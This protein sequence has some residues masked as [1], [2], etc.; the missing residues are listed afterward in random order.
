MKLFLP[1]ARATNFLLIVGFVSLGYALYIR[2]LGIEQ[3]QVGLSCAAGLDTWLC[4]SRRTVAILFQYSAFGTAA[5]IAI[6]VGVQVVS[7]GVLGAGLPLRSEATLAA[8]AE[9]IFGPAGWRM[10]IVCTA[11]ATFGTLAGDMLA[12]PRGFLPVSAA[13]LLPAAVAS[14]HPRYR[15]PH[16]AIGLYAGVA[17]VMALSGA[18][19]P[20]A[21]LSSGSILLV[22]FVVCVAAMRLRMRRPPPAGG[23][24]IPGGWTVPLAGV[25]IVV[26]LL[27]HLSATEAAALGGTVLVATL[28]Y[29]VRVRLMAVRSIS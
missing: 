21:V 11:L 13:G 17:C 10:M 8:V 29:A 19:K 24:R 5:L 9:R 23:F 4:A 26:W 12:S 3:T 22:Y 18:F 14:V 20:L 7:Q 15:T 2:Y 16:I 6:Y 27:A 1:S 28:Y 25:V